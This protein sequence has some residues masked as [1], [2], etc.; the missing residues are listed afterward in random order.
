M[1]YSTPILSSNDLV[2]EATP[3]ST[4]PFIGNEISA[5]Y[6]SILEW[7]ANTTYLVCPA[8]NQLAPP[9]DVKFVGD[10]NAE[11]QVVFR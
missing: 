8:V 3:P 7:K 5:S 11:P 9:A 6:H 10:P 2:V 1:E 4:P